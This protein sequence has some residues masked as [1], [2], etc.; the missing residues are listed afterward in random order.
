[1][2]RIIPGLLL[3]S[4]AG[5]VADRLDRKWTMVLSDVGRGVV[6]LGLVLADNLVTIAIISSVLEISPARHAL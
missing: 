4:L 6:V 1:M 5:V 2:S 3:G